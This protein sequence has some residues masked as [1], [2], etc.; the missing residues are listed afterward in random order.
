MIIS[1]N[2]KNKQI[3][4]FQMDILKKCGDIKIKMK[5]TIFDGVVLGFLVNNLINIFNVKKIP[6][7]YY[8]VF[9]IILL[10]SDFMVDKGIVTKN[11]WK[12]FIPFYILHLVLRD[13][14]DKTI[15]YFGTLTILSIIFVLLLRRFF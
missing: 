12:K 8:G 1:Y 3:N 2:I 6:F 10:I 4:L 14:I 5:I 13:F 9:L 11:W 7:L 15:L